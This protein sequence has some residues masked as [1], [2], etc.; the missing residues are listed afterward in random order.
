MS[1]ATDEK[2]RVLI[3]KVTALESRLLALEAVA[4]RPAILPTIVPPPDKRTREYKDW[5]NA[6]S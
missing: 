5:K 4:S 6:N 3:G 2:V 1:M